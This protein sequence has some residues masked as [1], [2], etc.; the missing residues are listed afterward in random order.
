MSVFP[1]VL[2]RFVE[3]AVVVFPFLTVLGFPPERVGMV[4]LAI[5]IRATPRAIATS[6]DVACIIHGGQERD[7][8]IMHQTTERH[9][10]V[11]AP[12]K[13]ELV[14]RLHTV[15]VEVVHGRSI[16]R[17]GRACLAF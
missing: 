9:K 2:A 10:L 12:A 15:S 14:A 5:R 16:H 11:T 3:A 7:R 6:D 13:S 8:G 4:H 1:C 17:M